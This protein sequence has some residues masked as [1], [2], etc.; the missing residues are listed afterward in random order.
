MI[1]CKAK[2]KNNRQYGQEYNQNKTVVAAQCQPS[3]RAVFL[4]QK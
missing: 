2:L 4:Q 1:L 3:L